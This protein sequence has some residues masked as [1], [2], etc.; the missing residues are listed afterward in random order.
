M[1][2]HSV[3]ARYVY[4]DPDLVKDPA[5]TADV[6]SP[7]SASRAPSCCPSSPR[8]GTRTADRSGSSTWPA[9]SRS[10]MGQLVINADLAGIGVRR[11][12]R[13]DVPGHDLAANLIGF[14]GRDLTGLDGLEASYDELLRGVD[15]KRVFEIGQPEG[16][17]DLDHEIPGGYSEETPARPGSSLQLTIDR[18]LQFEV[19]RILGDADGRGQGDHRRGGRARRAHRRGARPG[20][21]SVL[22][23]GQPVRL[24]AGR[25]GRRRRPAWSLDPGS[26]H[27]AIVFGACLQEGDRQAG[28]DSVRRA[29]DDH[30]GRH[31][32]RRHPPAQPSRPR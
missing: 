26:V 14:T 11:D 17:L 6:L 30:Q 20:Q 24:Q 7:S 29:A 9:A 31:D 2:A 12:E 19:Q 32:V 10:T 22:R 5:A 21:L 4:A 23:R 15:G 16:D 1:L 8:T 13:R 3:E 25:P 27:K 28:L 18:D